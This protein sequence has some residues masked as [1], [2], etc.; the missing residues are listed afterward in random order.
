MQNACYAAVN[1]VAYL[2][3]KRVRSLGVVV[4]GERS[5]VEASLRKHSLDQTLSRGQKNKLHID[6][7]VLPSRLRFFDTA[8][9]WQ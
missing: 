6:V 9:S 4:C 5:A 7:W 1:R 2:L 3:R 8:G